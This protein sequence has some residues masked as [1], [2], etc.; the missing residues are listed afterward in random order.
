[1]AQTACPENNHANMLYLAARCVDDRTH[2]NRPFPSWFV[3][4][5]TDRHSADVKE[6]KLPFF[7]NPDL[8]RY[9]EPLN[10][11]IIVLW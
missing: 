3:A 10:Q 9:L 11:Q 8:V 5:S 7:K 1:M 2:V 4:R 6:F